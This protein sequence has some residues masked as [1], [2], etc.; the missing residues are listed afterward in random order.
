MGNGLV[1]RPA[2]KPCNSP[3][4]RARA[5]CISTSCHRLLPGAS[6]LDAESKKKL[7]PKFADGQ[8]GPKGIHSRWYS[9]SSVVGEVGMKGP[10]FFSLQSSP[11]STHRGTLF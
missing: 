3:G 7:T 1:V 5:G 8:V 11:Y 9:G 10:L 2:R 6:R 4:E